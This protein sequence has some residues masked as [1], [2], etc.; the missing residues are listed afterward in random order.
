MPFRI[1][2]KKNNFKLYNLEKKRFVKRTFKTK[3]SATKM[4]KVYLNYDKKKKY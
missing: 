3:E 4:K 2:K 1:V